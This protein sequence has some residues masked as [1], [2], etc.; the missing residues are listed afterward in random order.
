MAIYGRRQIL[1]G[2]I[3]LVAAGGLLVSSRGTAFAETTLQKL[4]S[5]KSVA[6][7]IANEKPYGYVET[8]GKITG[9]IV[10]VIRAV[11][12]PLGVSDL[13]PVVTNFD[14]LIPGLNAGRFD[15]IGAGMY[16]KPK[17][18]EAITFTNPLTQA[19]GAFGAKKGNPK[20]LHS[21]K[22]VAKDPT[23][24]IGTQTG[25]SQVDEIKQAGINPD[26]V[27]LFSK[28][29]ESIAGLQAGRVDVIYYPD[30]E[31]NNLIATTA[32][33]NLERV[34]PYEQI[35]DASGKPSL[36][37]QSLGLRKGDADL[38][39][40]INKQLAEM[41]TNGKLLSTLQPFG[42]TQDEVPPADVTA[43][44]LCAG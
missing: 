11:M 7:G 23:A 38:V 42:F 34:A 17:R 31:I 24:K 9:A 40:A 16:V 29:T 35:L 43:K 4:Q 20:N 6:I 2:G 41:H 19:G 14:T 3:G 25:T 39:D 10:E 18:C 33:P 15:I 28:D 8:D 12:A 37:Y 32:D 44:Q 21:L 13:Q 30:L 22:D 5:S 36:N 27:V 1:R 26:Q